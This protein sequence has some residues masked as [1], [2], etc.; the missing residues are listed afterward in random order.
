MPSWVPATPT[1]SRHRG[2]ELTNFDFDFGVPTNQYLDLRQHIQA[3]PE[4][5]KKFIAASLKGWSFAI[6]NPGC[7]GEDDLRT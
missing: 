2:A 7:E 1:K 3:N 6:D 4:V 5:I